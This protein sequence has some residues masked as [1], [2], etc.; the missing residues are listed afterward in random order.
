MN[1]N[2]FAD[3]SSMCTSPA[4]GPDK[5]PDESALTGAAVPR[6]DVPL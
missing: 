4:G 5:D 3:G 6:R 2:V 1:V